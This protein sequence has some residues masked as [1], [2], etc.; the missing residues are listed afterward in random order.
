MQH[1]GPHSHIARLGLL[2]RA[3]QEFRQ[4]LPHLMKSN[5]DPVVSRQLPHIARIIQDETWLEAERRGC[6]VSS[7]DPAV[8][9]KVCSVVLRIGADLRA[10][11]SPDWNSPPFDEAA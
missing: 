7:D 4:T 5:L 3:L 8:R 6:P 9:E 2:A 10:R 1:T 11:L